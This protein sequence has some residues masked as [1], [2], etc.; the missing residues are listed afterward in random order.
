MMEEAES[1]QEAVVDAR[2]KLSPTEVSEII[3]HINRKAVNSDDSCPVCGD[4]NN[5]VTEYV[6]R[7]DIGT[8]PFTIG[9]SHQPVY[10]TICQSC[11]FVRLFNKLVVD[12]LIREHN[13]SASERSQGG[14][15]GS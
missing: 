5:F 2:I 4:P 12:H 14:S 9:G 1:P 13:K 10:T 8:D 3:D 6:S 15:D 7:V 11:G